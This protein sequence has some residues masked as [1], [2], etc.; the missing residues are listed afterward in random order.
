[1]KP[2]T[3]NATIGLLAALAAGFF[4]GVAF[5]Q[6]PVPPIGRPVPPPLPPAVVRPAAPIAAPVAAPVAAPDAVAPDADPDAAL[7][8]D[9]PAVEDAAGGGAEAGELPELKFEQAPSDMLLTAYATETGLTLLHDPAAPKATITLRSQSKLSRE[10]YLQAI[11]TVLGMNG[12]ALMPVGDKFLK[13]LPAKDLRKLGVK[14]ELQEPQGGLYPE[15]GRMVSQMIT[16]KHISIEEARKTIEGF[17][18]GDGQIQLFERTNSILVTDSVENV[19][20]MMEILRFID[21]PLLVREETNVRQIRFAKAT[22]VKRRLEEIISEAQKAQQ[23]AKDAPQSRPAGGPGITREAVTTAPGG[24]P[25]VIRAPS[26]VVARST[27][28]AE[29]EILEALVAEAERGVIRGKVQI[30]A[31][32]RTNLLI[33]IT[34][35]ENMTFFDRI[36]NVLDVETSPDVLVQVFRLE[37][38]DAEE[39]SGMLN[40]LIGN[41]KAEAPAAAKAGAT[42]GAAGADTPRSESLAD[43]AARTQ[44]GNA[45]RTEPG[46]SKIGELNKD[47][48]KILANKRTNAVIIMASGA[49][50]AA[51]K[52]IIKDLD[53]ML[54]QVLIETVILQVT[55]DDTLKTGIDWVQRAM[56]GYN[57]KGTPGVAFAGQG[58]GGTEDVR[59]PLSLTTTESFPSGV[60]GLAYYAT[61]FDLNLDVVMAAVATDSRTHVISSP[62]VLTQ[63]NKEALIEATTQQYFFKGKKYAGEAGGNPIYEDDVELKSYGT[64]VKV[65][66]QINEKGFVVMKID[67]SIESPGAG[68]PIGDTVWPTVNSRKLG[69]EVAVQSGQTI[70]LGGLVETTTI[71]SQSKIPLLGEIPLLGWFFRFRSNQETRTEVLV[72]LTPYVLDTPEQLMTE[73]RRIKDAASTEGG[74]WTRGWSNSQLAD[75]PKHAPKGEFRSSGRTN[76][77]APRLE[78]M[79]TVKLSDSIQPDGP[80]GEPVPLRSAPAVPTTQPPPADTVPEAPAA[81]AVPPAAP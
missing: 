62:V 66:P 29:N 12:I 10:E 19:N 23:Q 13:V 75:P 56:I 37:Y 15:E 26:S 53:I 42:P 77:V 22:D 1:M 39:V 80:V 49:D 45:A 68:Q 51:M 36:I 20:R 79:G 81:E 71:K 38:A 59:N 47:N 73:A 54:S 57:G 58:G 74:V 61:F 9:A 6:D 46:K 64:T 70:V 67:E 5:G 31:D 24:P 17:K 72:F 76:A 43:A 48:V 16:L 25:G 14:T 60:G 50:L 32:E 4:T 21:Q 41:K 52:E 8:E 33:L 27:P 78:R 69:A 35:P 63:D 3:W 2:I 28:A 65:T 40:D 55:L 34:R 11:E 44:Q 18:R 30:V 7:E